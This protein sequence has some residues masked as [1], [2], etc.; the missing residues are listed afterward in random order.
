MQIQSL[1]IEEKVV[2]VAQM[3]PWS[4]EILAVRGEV[5]GVDGMDEIYCNPGAL[6]SFFDAKGYFKKQD[7]YGHHGVMVYGDYTNE[8]E[9]LAGML[10]ME[11]E[12]YHA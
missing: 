3:N 7:T 12:V 9:R 5:V 2:T 8:L 6:I 11:I 1:K 4:D 10:D